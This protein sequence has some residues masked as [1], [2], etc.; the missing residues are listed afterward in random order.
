MHALGG[1]DENAGGAK[2]K[3]PAPTLLASAELFEYSELFGAALLSEAWTR[4]R[5][6]K[7]LPAQ[8]WA[9][10][11]PCPDIFEL[12]LRYFENVCELDIMTHLDKAHFVVDEMICN[13]FIIE[14]SK[15]NILEPIKILE[16]H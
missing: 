8:A 3:E 16:K 7:A 12:P 10:P 15:A 9:C 6:L 11:T 1:K 5:A 14:T 13:G 4:L 2:V